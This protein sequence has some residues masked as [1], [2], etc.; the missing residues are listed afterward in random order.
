MFIPAAPEVQPLD[1]VRL[2]REAVVVAHLFRSE[3]DD[4]GPCTVGRDGYKLY[5]DC[6]DTL[7]F[8]S[9]A[10]VRDL[11]ALRARLYASTQ[12]AIEQV[13]N[14]HWRLGISFHLAVLQEDLLPKEIIS[15]ASTLVLSS[16]AEGMVDRLPTFLQQLVALSWFAVCSQIRLHEIIVQQ[17][18]DSV[19]V[20]VDRYMDILVNQTSELQ[21]RDSY[22]ARLQK[23]GER[24]DWSDPEKMNF[25]ILSLAL[26]NRVL[27]L[28][29]LR[30]LLISRMV[31][32]LRVVEIRRDG[33]IQRLEM[34]VDEGVAEWLAQRARPAIEG[35]QPIIPFAHSENA[36]AALLDPRNPYRRGLELAQTIERK[37]GT[38]FVEFA[39]Q[40]ACA[41]AKVLRF[42]LPVRI[43]KTVREDAPWHPNVRF[44]RIAEST[45]EEVAKVLGA[46]AEVRF[47]A[48]FALLDRSS[49]PPSYYGLELLNKLE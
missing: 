45:P 13:G 29:G 5:A 49:P 39:A 4:G 8:F 44:Q 6:L 1:L 32:K 35:T 46:P 26:S 21:A 3:P 40:V 48:L 15:L 30:S 17:L 38:G 2:E 36:P 31:E 14:R 24:L 22:R 23:I 47:M 9:V 27:D 19:L 42:E 41:Y 25:E 11:D 33:Q 20:N 7:P 37:F 10:E 28:D 16:P 18:G 12:K 34:V 43:L